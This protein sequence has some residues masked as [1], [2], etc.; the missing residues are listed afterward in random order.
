MWNKSSNNYIGIN[1][2][3]HLTFDGCDTVDL[4]AEFGSPLYVM[5]E[6]LLR[7]RCREIKRDF[8]DQHGNTMALYASKAFLCAAMCRIIAEEGLGL[9]VVSGGELYLALKA[10]FPAERIFFHGNNK[11][12]QEIYFAVENGIGCMVVDSYYEME[13]LQKAASHF[14]SNV[15]VLLRVSPGIAPDTH[16]YISTGQVDCKFGFPILNDEAIK[17][18]K[19]LED[20]PNLVFKG[21]HCHIGSQ[22][23]SVD[24]Y[25]HSAEVM[26][27]FIKE[28]SD[29]LSVQT[30]VLNLG[31]GFGI[32]YCEGS[33]TRKI[34][35][36]TDEM[37][38]VVKNRFVQNN[39]K[40]PTIIIEPGRWIAGEAG[41]TLYSIGTIK[42]IEGVRIYASVDGGMTDNPRPAMYKAKY[43]AVIANK[44]NLSPKKKVS[45]AGKCC[46]S[47]DMLIWD[48]MVPEISSKDVLAVFCTGAYNYSMSSN[49]NKM[50]KPAV[51]F[52]SGG[53][54]R[55]VV[56][57]ES[58]EDLIKNEI[59]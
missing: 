48:L 31:G 25:K 42:E 57:R 36:Y 58:Y 15:E 35:E 26:C 12:F 9:D 18:V 5:S 39:L 24:S 45:I 10:G 7:D 21:L 29:R 14:G 6:N 56:R 20:F 52:V 49:Y 38:R 1:E 47:G 17:A 40:Q 16:S 51:V 43:E 3:G 54:A 37:M 33:A 27:A 4:L 59:F 41:I 19:K 44:A 8:I 50:T 32:Q 34:R 11:S 28:I 55:V 30:E 2:K 22:I 23:F 46:E 53:N 13:L